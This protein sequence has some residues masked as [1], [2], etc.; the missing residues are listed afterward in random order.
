[1][2]YALELKKLVRSTLELDSM[3]T[4]QV[5]ERKKSYENISPAP[6]QSFDVMT[7]AMI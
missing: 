3:P 4:L 6:S 1:M 7:G 5:K 2:R